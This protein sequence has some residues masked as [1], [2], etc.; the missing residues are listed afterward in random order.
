VWKKLDDYLA[1]EFKHASGKSMY[2]CATAIDSRGH[3]TQAVYA[4][5]YLR[6]G[7]NTFAIAGH[8]GKE[9]AIVHGSTHVD[10]DWK[11]RRVKR[12]VTLWQVGTNLAKDLILNRL[13]LDTPGAGYIHLS[14][15]LPDE[16]FSQ[17]TGE[18]RATRM[19]V[20]GEES[21][22]VRL[23]G[24]RVEALDCRVYATFLEYYLQLDR[25]PASFWDRLEERIQPKN[26][27][28]F[29]P[30]SKRP[31]VDIAPPPPSRARGK[32]RRVNNFA[33]GW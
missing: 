14:D 20:Y 27:D 28:F 18:T 7:K 22:W 30:E 2:I 9:R 6:R 21:R 16:Y 33:T 32:S 25:R 12:G 15:E 13:N 26:R 1:T 23:P 3:N 24:R 19:T 10:L 4:W 17:I 29:E 8:S 5:C 11:G 31:E